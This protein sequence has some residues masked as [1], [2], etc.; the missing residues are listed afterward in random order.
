[1]TPAHTE[2]LAARVAACRPQDRIRGAMFNA[3]V[4]LVHTRLGAEARDAVRA[5][6]EAPGALK[7]LSSYPATDFLKLLFTAADL[8]RGSGSFDD[9]LQRC[10]EADV[11]AFADS[12]VGG[13]FFG[14]LSLAKPARLAA[15]APSG[16]ASLVTYGHRSWASTGEASGVLH[17]EGD[18]Q[19]PRYHV[20]V[21]VA[22]MRAIGYAAVV[23]PRVHTLTACDYAFSWTKA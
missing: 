15:Q 20:G 7:D 3:I 19:P 8:L 21:I 18:M 2:E 1:M 11:M 22:G 13:L 10:G 6:V 9:A 4:Q 16:Y 14:M 12:S 17:M 23:E 5:Q